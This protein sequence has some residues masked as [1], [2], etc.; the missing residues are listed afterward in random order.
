M[1]TEHPDKAWINETIQTLQKWLDVPAFSPTSQLTG[2]GAIGSAERRLSTMH[3]NRHALLM[4]SATFGMLSVLKA[5]DVGPGDEVLIPALD[6]SSTLAAVRTLGATPIPVDVSPQTWTVDPD[7]AQRSLSQKTKAIVACHFLGIPADVPTLREALPNTPIVEDCAQALG[8][9]IDGWKVGTLG[10]AG[11]FSFGPTKS[12]DVGEAGAVVTPHGWLRDAVLRGSAHP[13][14]Q[15]HGGISSVEAAPLNVRVHPI[16]A[17]LLD[18]FLRDFNSRSLI[19]RHQSLTEQLRSSTGMTPLGFD[20]RREVANPTL[21][22]DAQDLLG[23]RLPATLRAHS[24]QVLDIK[25][26]IN[27]AS[28][29]RSVASLGQAPAHGPTTHTSA[30]D[31][32]R[33]PETAPPSSRA[34]GHR[35]RPGKYTHNHVGAEKERR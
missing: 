31:H 6:W 19:T 12:I 18:I 4:P 30:V 9:T 3:G 13:L 5:L 2:G 14:R 15:I 22:V 35:A 21:P 32:T 23:I 26:L 20:S 10:D 24:S 29:S 16:A 28:T 33:T 17:V 34:T 1:A 8:S 7:A 11:I 27:G 25:A